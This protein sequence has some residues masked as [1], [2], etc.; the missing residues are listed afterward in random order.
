MKT[1]LPTLLILSAILAAVCYFV[2]KTA[3]LEPVYFPIYT[4]LILSFGVIVGGVFMTQGQTG[5]SLS[6]GGNQTLFVGNL[7]Y[8]ATQTDVRRLFDQYG[9]VHSTRLVLDR[10][11][12]RSKG[13]GFV[14]MDKQAALAAQKKLDGAEFQGRSLKV[15][16]ANDQSP[17]SNRY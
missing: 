13:Y 6:P 1:K 8:Q 10:V 12:R 11:T 3:Q 15:S 14:E 16:C 17:R 4:S 9:N 7:P 5:N 2:L